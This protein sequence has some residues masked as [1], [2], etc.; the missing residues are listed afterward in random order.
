MTR[1]SFIFI[2]LLFFCWTTESGFTATIESEVK[3]TDSEKIFLSESE[4]IYN[5]LKHSE[6]GS[7]PSFEAFSLALKGF[8]NLKIVP[9]NLKKDIL[10]IV[11]FSL[12]SC[13]KRLWVIDMKKNKVLYN[14]LVAHGKNSG[15]NFAKKFSNI[16]NTNM[17]SL[18]FYVTGKTYQGKHG[19][20]LYLDGMDRE[21]NANARKRSIVM[22]GAKYVSH[23][24]IKKYG[25]L[26][27]SL[28]CPSL[29]MD[30]YKDVIQTIQGGSCLFIYYPDKQ[31][32]AKSTILNPVI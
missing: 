18:G 1:K 5:N 7:L 9:E 3:K 12:S 15:A 16:P 30:I 23:D 24:F 21:L 27:R 29:S 25:R 8:N 31:F 2:F 19:L 26:G 14:D 28:G 17:S 22:H 20:S 11:D 10:T 32:L 6:S 4:L 13:E